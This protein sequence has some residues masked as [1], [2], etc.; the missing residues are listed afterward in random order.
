[1]FDP[2]SETLVSLT[3]AAKLLPR[4]RR[5]SKPNVAT[6]YRWTTAGCRGVVLESIQVGGTRCTSR[7]AL[8]R[9]LAALTKPGSTNVESQPRATVARRR[10]QIASAE[11]FC[12]SKGF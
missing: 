9:F 8:G 5:G 11:A 7:E 3:D 6:L 4:R 1:M 10:R 12:K 2:L